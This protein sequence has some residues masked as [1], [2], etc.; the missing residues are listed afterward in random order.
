M[1]YQVRKVLFD[2]FLA[3]LHQTNHKPNKMW[4]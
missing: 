3:F 1:V 2:V 4:D